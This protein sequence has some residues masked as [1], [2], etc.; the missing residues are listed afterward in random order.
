MSYQKAKQFKLIFFKKQTSFVFFVTLFCCQI[1][2]LA[3]T[4]NKDAS[5]ISFSENKGQWD[6]KILY[7]AALD[8]GALF[9]EKNAFTYSFYDKELLH[10]LHLASKSELQKISNTNIRSHAFRI[11]FVNCLPIHSTSSYKPTK[12]YENYFIGRNRSQWVSNVKKYTQ[13]LYPNLYDKIDM[14][15][16]G[17]TNSIKYNFIVKPNANP[18]QIKM[19]YDGL[20]GIE[21]VKGKLIIKTTL[22]E[23]TEQEPYAYQWIDGKKI[24]VPCKFILNGTT[25][26]FGLGNYNKNY[27]LVIDP[28]LI[29]GSYSGSTADNFGMTAT[30]DNRGHLYAG[31]TAFATG[32]PITVGAF[33]PTYNGIV[34]SGRTDVVITKYDSAGTSLIYSTYIGGANSTEVVSSIIVNDQ[35]ELLLYGATGSNDFPVTPNAYDT[36]FAGGTAFN[37]VPNG[38]NFQN[39]TDLYIAKFDAAGSS[40]IGCTYVGGTKNDGVNSSGT[41]AY[42]YGDYYRGEITLDPNGNCYIA[43][44]TYSL[45][46]PTV[47]PFQAVQGGGIDGVVFKM[48]PLLTTL[49]WSSYIGGTGEDGAYAIAVDDS[50]VSYVTGGT[51]S[52]NFP[53]TLGSANANY[54]GGL[55]DGFIAKINKTGTAI[56]SASYIGTPLYDQCFFVQLD[57]KKRVYLVGQT[58]GAFPVSGGVYSNPNSGQFIVK[59]DNNLTTYMYST[60][61]GNGNGIPNISPSAFL[62]DDC[63]NVYV[64]GWGGHI[65]NGTPTNN[66]PLTNNAFQNTTDGFNF[67]LIVF[68]KDIQALIYATYFGGATSQEH[69]DGGTSRFDKKGIVYQSVC[70]GC[71]SNDDFPTTVG[72]WSQTNNSSNCNN[73]VFKFD[74]QVKLASSEFTTSYQSQ[75][76][77]ATVQFNNT[78]PNT[79]SFLWDFGNND[80]TSLISNPIRTYNNPGTYLVILIVNDTSSCN[81][82]DTSFQ[83]IT[84]YPPLVADFNFTTQPCTNF[85]QFTDSSTAVGDTAANWA[86]DFGD[87]QS[88]NIKNPQHTY[89]ANGTY[90]VTLISSTANGCADTV[91]V[92]VV[93]AGVVANVNADTTICQGTSAQLNASGGFAYSWSP[94]TGLSNTNIPNPTA[95]PND[96]TTYTVV[97]SVVNNNGDT[98]LVTLTTTVNVVV[99]TVG[100]A[101]LTSDRDTIFKGESVQLTTTP[102]NANSYTWLPV[103]GLSDPSISNPIATPLKTTTYTVFI[104]GPGGCGITKQI[105]IVVLSNICDE[106]DIFIP[107]T[108]TPNGDGN[109]DIFNVR[110]NNIEVSYLAVYNRWGEKIFDSNDKKTGWDGTYKN[111]PAKPDVFA[112]YVKIKCFNGKEYFKKGNITLIR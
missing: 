47:N 34:Q 70:A 45:D 5:S 30:Y 42:N 8:G 79:Q 65:L 10:K 109:N 105:T 62:V 56:L 57:K 99:L 75:C 4:S 76:A 40:L 63:E 28:I 19:N 6:K 53:T 98:C 29:F 20:S 85:V 22:Q 83:Y 27:E 88:S 16:I 73:G 102:N 46:F 2:C 104:A 78:N 82:V 67:Y 33:D 58:L 37:N 36:T 111:K 51:S 1:N 50:S 87:G 100:N 35:N 23:I 17:L 94:A 3:N 25:I 103:E 9:L 26:S 54:L 7:R 55:T 38:T 108:F 60:V 110:G 86:W 31:G 69:V 14:E 72:A 95:A 43:S 44:F 39:G 89:N 81:K 18:E 80:T 41:L 11:N 91:V 90:N 59:L 61:F 24:D 77:P 52:G 68:S 48:N 64:S 93:F 21:L 74:F 107:N 84:I 32:Y 92:Q 96:T 106:P 112:Y 12:D 49:I 15:I 101:T 66:M 13:V 97:V 71:G